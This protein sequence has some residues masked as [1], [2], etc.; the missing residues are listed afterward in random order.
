MKTYLSTPPNPD[1]MLSKAVPA[2]K[3]A[4][5]LSPP[6]FSSTSYHISEY[7][8][9]KWHK[10]GHISHFTFYDPS[11]II[12]IIIAT[13]ILYNNGCV[14]VNHTEPLDQTKV[15]NTSQGQPTS[16]L[17]IIIRMIKDKR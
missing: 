3:E 12:F 13:M 11:I 10:A 6:P 9:V 7:W 4:L 5:N 14:P 16:H 8:N 1:Q 15:I 2:H 17:I